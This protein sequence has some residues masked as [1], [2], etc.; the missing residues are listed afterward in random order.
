MIAEEPT[1]AMI[2]LDGIQSISGD[3]GPMFASGACAHV[4]PKEYSKHVQI[5]ELSE[6]PELFSA[7]GRRMRV[8]EQRLA[9]F[10]VET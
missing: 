5:T 9:P 4:A 3:G 7:T 8:Y 10:T 1:L 6:E 2:R